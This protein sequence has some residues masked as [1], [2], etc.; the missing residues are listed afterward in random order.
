MRPQP[1][2]FGLRKRPQAAKNKRTRT[3]A[4]LAVA[5][6]CVCLLAGGF[7]AWF[8]A[9]SIALAQAV[10]EAVQ[11]AP[12]DALVIPADANV[13]GAWSEVGTWPVIAVHLVLMPDGRVLSYGTDGTGKQTGFFN[14][15][16]LGFGASDSAAAT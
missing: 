13:K 7:G 11:P 5:A 10:L 3:R 8:K 1:T 2:L 9:G 14:L 6:A 15:R 12:F 4:R 16:R